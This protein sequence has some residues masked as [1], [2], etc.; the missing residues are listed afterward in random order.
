MSLLSEKG[1]KNIHC[2]GNVEP[3]ERIIDDVLEKNGISVQRFAEENT[4]R[5]CLSITKWIIDS[6]KNLEKIDLCLASLSL[7]QWPELLACGCY[8]SQHPSALLLQDNTDLDS[9][10]S[11]LDF[12]NNERNHVGSLI[13][14]GDHLGLSDGELKMLCNQ[15][16][17]PLARDT[18]TQNC[19][20]VHDEELA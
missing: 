1:I 8:A 19:L 9:I 17:S 7:A 3:D 10:A 11:S 20:F 4:F 6:E 15:L 18:T 5:T 16:H 14:I 12:V 13:S 2:F